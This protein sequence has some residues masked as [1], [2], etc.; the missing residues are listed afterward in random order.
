MT[1][2]PVYIFS[3]A[4]TVEIGQLF[5]LVKLLQLEDN[6]IAR[7]IIGTTYD[8]NDLICYFVGCILLVMWQAFTKKT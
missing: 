6:V 2:L 1:L 7:I 5:N 3:F 4:A 8:T